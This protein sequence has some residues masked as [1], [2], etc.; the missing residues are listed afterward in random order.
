MLT[1]SAKNKGRRYENHIVQK[2]KDSGLDPNAGRTPGSGSGNHDKGDIRS[3]IPY[4]IE[5]KNHAGISK[6]ILDFVDQAK[7]AARSSRSDRSK[8]AMVF[9]DPRTPEVNSEDYVMI[10]FDE[11]LQLLKKNK[12]PL[13]KSEDKD[14]AYKI[15]KFIFDGKELLK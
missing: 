8:W 14:L 9:R 11:F 15:K 1:S 6:G 3:T 5:C 2:I 7:E 10:E 13:I 4:L 12:E